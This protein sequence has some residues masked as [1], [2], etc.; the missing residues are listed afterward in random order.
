MYTLK[1]L[2]GYSNR[3]SGHFISTKSDLFRRQLRYFT[4]NGQKN[5]LKAAKI[6][7]R[8]RFVNHA[9]LTTAGFTRRLRAILPPETDQRQV[10]LFHL[11]DQP[12]VIDLTL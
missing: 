6:T 2:S 10:F 3:W 1:I 9:S 5:P 8:G 12:G 7:L 11:F 4:E